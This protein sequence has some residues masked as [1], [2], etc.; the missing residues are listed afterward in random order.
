MGEAK[1]RGSYEQR[2]AEGIAKRQEL[3]AIAKKIIEDKER[4]QREHWNS[5]SIEDKKALIELEALMVM[6]QQS[7][8]IG[9]PEKFKELL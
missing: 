9:I 6:A 4:E 8:P 1:R 5:L 3:V 2:K 7:T